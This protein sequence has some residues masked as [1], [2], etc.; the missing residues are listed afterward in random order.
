MTRSSN[1]TRTFTRC[2]T[3][4][5]VLMSL[6]AC[7]GE[8]FE[9]IGASLADGDEINIEASTADGDEVDVTIA[10]EDD[11]T[12]GVDVVIGGD[13]DG[14]G[15]PVTP[16]PPEEPPVEEP[17]VEEPPVEEPPVE[18]P[19]VEE[20]PAEETVLT[21][22]EVDGDISSDGSNP[23]A[24]Q[25]ADGSSVLSGSVGAGDMDYVTV[26][27]PEGSV[28]S[29]IN[30]VDYFNVDAGTV[31]FIGVQEGT[32]F[33]EP[34]E[35]ANVGNLLGFLLY[36]AE[37]LDT[38]ILPAIGEGPGTQGFTGPLGAGAYTFWINETGDDPAAYSFEFVVS[39]DGDSPPVEEPPVE[40]PPVEEP[41]ER[42]PVE[43]PP[44]EEPPEPIVDDPEEPEEPEP[45]VVPENV[46]PVVSFSSPAD[47]DTFDMGS[48]LSVTV[49]AADSDGSVENVTLSIDGELVRQENVSPY[50]W[51]EGDSALQ[52]LA[53]GTHE[54]TAVATDDAGDSTEE[55][56]TIT[57]TESEEPPVVVAPPAGEDVFTGLGDGND[58]RFKIQLENAG[59]NPPGDWTFL[60]S[61][62]SD[63]NQAGFQGEGYY[64]YGDEESQANNRSP[65]EAEILEYKI[66]IPEGATGI[67]DLN[68]STSRDPG[69][70]NDRR[71][72]AWFR[73]SS[74][75][76]SSS[77]RDFLIENGNDPEPF[78]DGFIKVFGAS[79]TIWNRVS[80]Y[81]GDPGNID[82]RLEID[83]PGVYTV[84]IAGRSQGFHLDFF[85]LYKGDEPGM[86]AADTPLPG[87]AEPVEEP[88]VVVVPDE[89]VEGP[90]VEEPPVEEPVEEPPVVVIPDEPVEEP[91][92]EEPPVEEPPVEEPPVVAENSVPEVSFASPAD[93][94]SFDMGSL[95]SVT[96][97][98]S[99]SDGSVDNVILSI[100]GAIVRQ[101]NASP[102][103]WG[104]ADAAL[105]NLAAG[106]YEL[107]ALATD[108]AGDSSESTITI[109]IIESEE[110]PVVPSSGGDLLSL[111]YDNAPDDDDTHALV[112]GRVLVDTFGVRAMAINGT[113]GDGRR[114]QFNRESEEVFAIAWPN[115]LD[116]FN[117]RDGSIVAAAAM[118]SETISNGGTVY[119]AEGGP[120]D[121]T[122][123]VL[124]ELPAGQRSSVT[125]VQ[126]SD[127]NEINTS[128]SNFDFVRD[129]TNYIRIDDGN[130]PN[131]DTADLETR[132]NPTGFINA[133]RDSV[134]SEAWNAAFD[135]LNPANRLDFSDTVE[136][137]F[138]LDVP[139][140]RV[141]DWN[142][143]SD[144]F[145]VNTR[146]AVELSL[147]NRNFPKAWVS[148]LSE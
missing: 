93:G 85:E 7:D 45:P 58:F 46:V 106:T 26:N 143:F 133:A 52:N 62:D 110:E 101:E 18:E 8:F 33:T 89:P 92:V 9:G 136:A 14:D 70:A 119:V 135:F 6:S 141:A 61:A 130:H 123:E 83:E 82:T 54:L 77:T 65:V 112:A 32:V 17:P 98:A 63:G 145:L 122:V 125:V 41:P 56:I 105:Q 103:E 81:D 71:N 117:D 116:A 99:D 68:F 30:L 22:E 144:E 34:A 97:N 49:D 129:V 120:S 5:A 29:A 137:L 64:L 84:E 37:L 75:D 124:R 53:P 59:Q 111:H 23:L 132:S 42:P 148:P 80:R 94:A 139:L 127:W 96:V 15:E 35:D 128:N 2:A 74:E 138:I 44:V 78:E 100:D 140:S 25:L 13:T 67:Y 40:G 11:G 87:T 43:E 73:L 131:N 36:G 102:Y 50:E 12:I 66:M 4:L 109:T 16:E 39:A 113:Y 79:D 118:W 20:P 90:P 60:S 147:Q 126:H 121:F 86:N 3:S 108:D 115:G 27:V 91:P 142:D 104:G 47:G 24:F 55:T 95:L 51:G 38:N 31:S 114:D 134:W 76:G 107:S 21:D 146:Q 57:I 1:K 19:P 88:P 72:D 28:L 10:A 69:G 48:V